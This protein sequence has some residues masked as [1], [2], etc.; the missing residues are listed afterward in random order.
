M[1]LGELDI[2]EV[3]N[4]H[5]ASSA[6]YL[7]KGQH[8]ATAEDCFVRINT[9][10]RIL[11]PGDKVTEIEEVDIDR[12]M[13]RRRLES[14]TKAK[15]KLV[16]G[17]WVEPTRYPI[18]P[19][20]VNAEFITLLRRILKHAA[21]DKR[22]KALMPQIEWKD[23][24]LPEPEPYLR[25]YTPEQRAAWRA[26]CDP[27]AAFFLDL[28][29]TYGP[30]FGELFFHPDRFY[31]AE[32]S[33]EGLPFVHIEKRKKKMMVLPLRDDDARQIAARVGIARANKLPNIWVE[34]GPGGKLVSVTYDGMHARLESAAARAGLGDMPSV[35][36][37]T[38]H[39]AGTVMLQRTRNLK[40]SQQLLGHVS[41]QSTMRYAMVLNHDLR[42]ALEQ[43]SR[44]SPGPD[45]GDAD[46]SPP[47]QRRRK[48]R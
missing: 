31:P 46:F 44:N 40:S 41:I 21:K 29:F 14:Y 48:T 24:R 3:P 2:D 13:Q 9:L 23:L 34:T 42:D 37:G 32:A 8:L 39:H 45:F 28:L 17:K 30:R 35:I 26:Q 11:G 38:R 15:R 47:K 19:A 22:V 6:W 10:L 36:H 18:Q 27:T 20:T 33:E 16:K 1:T 7:A 12:G 4:L 5:Q 25:I 43:E